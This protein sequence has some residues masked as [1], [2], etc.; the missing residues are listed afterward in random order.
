MGVFWRRR[1]SEFRGRWLS[2]S[3]VGSC[4]MDGVPLFSCLSRRGASGSGGNS[5]LLFISCTCRD[6][7]GLGVV[8]AVRRASVYDRFSVTVLVQISFSFRYSGHIL[9]YE[10]CGLWQLM[11]LAFSLLS[12]S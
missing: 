6:V 2:V 11:H 5:L 10:L 3:H 4:E 1:A 12:I 8:G 7:R 9:E